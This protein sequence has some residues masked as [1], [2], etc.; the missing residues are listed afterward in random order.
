MFEILERNLIGHELKLL[1]HCIPDFVIDIG[2][3]KVVLE[4]LQRNAATLVL[5]NYLPRRSF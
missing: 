4:I 2:F 1:D 3:S 5:V